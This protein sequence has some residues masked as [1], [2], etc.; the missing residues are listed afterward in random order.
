[1]VQAKNKVELSSKQAIYMKEF[2]T[3]KIKKE[4]TA[5]SKFSS[6]IPFH[7]IS[8]SLFFFWHPIKR[9]KQIELMPSP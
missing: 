1:M 4:F 5:I 6:I 2:S 9:I 3:K 8:L 7:P